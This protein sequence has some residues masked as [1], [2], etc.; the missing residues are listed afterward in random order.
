[1]DNLIFQYRKL[2]AGNK[3]G[4]F[5]TQ[6]NR[7]DEAHR[8]VAALRECGKGVGKWEN[9][10]KP[11]VQAIVDQWKKEGLASATIKNRMST[12]RWSMEK[13]G[14]PIAKIPNA[15]YGIANRVYV[16]NIDK[17]ANEEAGRN[18]IKKLFSGDVHQQ[19]IAC[20]MELMRHFGLRREEA[21]KFHPGKTHVQNIGGMERVFVNYGTKGGRDRWVPITSEKQREL[22]LLATSLRSQTGSLISGGYTER[23]WI[24][25]MYWEAQQAGFCQGNTGTFHSLRHSYAQE[26]FEQMAGFKPRVCFGSARDHAKHANEQMGSWESAKEKERFARDMLKAELGHG[27]ERDDVISQYV[28]SPLRSA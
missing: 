27:P 9:I 16:R 18:A 24:N 15:A 8:I 28:G 22:L 26:R 17:G 25:K 11:H 1:M 12:L 21:I 3:E 19:R 4:S 20:S 2:A 7:L 6:H 5:K 23:S 10:T 13:V 14:N